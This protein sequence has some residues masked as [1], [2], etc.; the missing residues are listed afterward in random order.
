MSTVKQRKKL[1][2]DFLHINWKQGK[3]IFN[4]T[5]AIGHSKQLLVPLKPQSK[6]Y[7]KD[8]YP[9]NRIVIWRNVYVESVW[10]NHDYKRT[11]AKLINDNGPGQEENGLGLEENR[12]GLEEISHGQEEEHTN[13]NLPHHL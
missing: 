7:L 3:C 6:V 4:T 13:T 9:G 11:C 2:G 1:K 5:L 12:P 8:N 10:D